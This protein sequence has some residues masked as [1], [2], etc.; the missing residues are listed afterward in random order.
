MIEN[1]IWIV[2]GFFVLVSI[3]DIKFKA[4]PSVLMTGMIFIVAFIN[5]VFV[6]Q[7]YFIF[8]ILAF[9]FAVFL[10]ELDEH[11]GIADLKATV[12]I[13]FMISTYQS[14]VLFMLILA[15]IQVLYTLFIRYVIKVKGD[16][17]FLPVYLITYTLLLLG[18]LS[19]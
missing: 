17:P 7:S 9:I 11:R 4:V 12:I 3:L 5:G 8:G 1:L 14:F 6:N 10:H 15:I 2:L 13:G 16:F 18:G 19:I